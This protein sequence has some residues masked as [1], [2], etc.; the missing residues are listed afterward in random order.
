M[1]SILTFLI[2][3]V[4]GTTTIIAQFTDQELHKFIKPEIGLDSGGNVIPGPSLPFG[5]VKLIS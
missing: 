1:R 3:I 2:F 5:M 4:L